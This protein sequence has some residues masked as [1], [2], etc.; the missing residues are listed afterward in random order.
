MI[1]LLGSLLR[2]LGCEHVQSKAHA[3]DF[4]FGTT[5]YDNEMGEQA[6]STQCEEKANEPTSTHFMQKFWMLVLVLPLIS[7]SNLVHFIPTFT[8]KRHLRR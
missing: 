3:L 1:P 2:T 5:N 6:I 4:S 8:E 7:L